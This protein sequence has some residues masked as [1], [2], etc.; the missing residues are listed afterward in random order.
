MTRP[1]ALADLDA[2]MDA[3][4]ANSL[5]DLHR[6]ASEA[7]AFIEA[8]RYLLLFMPKRSKHGRAGTEDE[9]DP[10]SVRQLLGKAER[11]YAANGGTNNAGAVTFGGFADYRG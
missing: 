8:C 3:Y 1:M 11:W 5:Y 2:A 4:A 6:S 7:M 10:E 9:F